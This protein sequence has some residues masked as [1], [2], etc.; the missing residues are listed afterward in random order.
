MECYKEVSHLHT[1]IQ[2]VTNNERVESQGVNSNFT[3]S[4][5]H[6]ELHQRNI[7]CFQSMQQEQQVSE[8]HFISL[9]VILQYTNYLVFNL[10][11]ICWLMLENWARIWRL[12]LLRWF[13]LGMFSK[14]SVLSSSLVSLESCASFQM[15]EYWSINSTFQT[16]NIFSMIIVC[17][18]SFV[19]RY[20]YE[21]I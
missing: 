6:Q 7:S 11:K 20:I 13:L 9:D 19:C 12:D 17:I 1:S 3:P 10:R 8:I 16:E 14:F 5:H 4:P 15:M 2:P 18:L 21:T